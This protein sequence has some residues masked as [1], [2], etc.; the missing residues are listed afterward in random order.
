MKAIIYTRVSTTGQVNDGGSLASQER[1]CREYAHHNGYEVDKVFIEKGESATT[2]KRHELQ[3]MMRYCI[4][5]KRGINAVIVYKLDRM[6]RSSS[7]YANL[8]EYF[9]KYGVRII[10]ATEPFGDNPVGHYL[11]G[12]LALNAQLENEIRA[13][14]CRGGMVS[15]AEDGRWM[16]LA[17]LGYENARV[18]GKKN[19]VPEDNP[20]RIALIKESW[21]LIDSG[22]S[23]TEAWR[24]VVRKGLTGKSGKPISFQAFSKMLRKKIYMG[25][26]ETKLTEELISSDTIEPLIDK[27]LWWRV[28]NRLEGQK[29]NPSKYCMVNPDFPLRG[30]LMCS[31]GHKMTGSSSRGSS[32]I[33]YRKYH[34]KCRGKG[35]YYDATKVERDFRDYAD[36][37]S[38]NPLFA[39]ALAEAVRLNLDEEQALDCKRRKQLEKELQDLDEY[40][41]DVMHKNYRGVISDAYM[42][43][44]LEANDR[45]ALTIK[46]E[47]SDLSDTILVTEQVLDFGIEVLSHIGDTL[48]SLDDINT[49]REFQS[50]LFPELVTFYGDK[51]GTTRLP[52]CLCINR[53]EIAPDSQVVE[54]RRIE[55]RSI[56]HNP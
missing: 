27:E 28:Y 6:A 4:S 52:R 10:S 37:L 47:L 7:D 17:P 43:K 29:D 13:E 20:L 51:F 42:Q 56:L 5:A 9:S 54:A 31:E 3:N 34:C 18:N 48:D 16:W 8:K 40:S 39:K 14:R 15:G 19:L 33:Y 49:R 22:Y 45:K 26:I 53:D 24:T 55:L 35:K 2:T 36:T 12:S 46:A 41:L 11:E 44:V 1:I 23:V 30:L 38:Y 25:V 50:W 32:G 21:E